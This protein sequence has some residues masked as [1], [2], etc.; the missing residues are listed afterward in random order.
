[1]VW[2]GDFCF[3]YCRVDVWNEIESKIEGC[4]WTDVYA[5][6]RADFYSFIVYYGTGFRS[7]GVQIE[8]CLLIDQ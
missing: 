8:I 2:W 6:E 4:M 5:K 1:M 7:V 3:L